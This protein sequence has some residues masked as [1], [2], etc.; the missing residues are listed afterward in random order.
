MYSLNWV[1][2]R[3]IKWD[4]YGLF[5]LN[6][7]KAMLQSGVV[8]HPYQIDTL[9]WPTWLQ[10]EGGFNPS[11]LSVQ[12][13]PSYETLPTGGQVWNYTMWEATQVEDRWFGP[14]RRNATRLLVPHE[15]LVDV[16]KPHINDVPIHVVPGGTCP[17]EF[18]IAHRSPFEVG[19]PYTF[20][21]LGDRGNRKGW[22]SVWRCFWN[23]F[24]DSKDV[25]LIIKA[26]KGGLSEMWSAGW[27]NRVVFYRDDVDTMREVY[28]LADCFVFPSRGEGWGMPPREFA[29]TGK[30][31]IATRWSGL[32]NGL[33]HWGLPLDKVTLVPSTLPGG[34]EWAMVDDDELT[35]KM[36]WCFENRVEARAKGLKAAQWLR[37]NQTWM[38]SA[39]AMIKLME[40]YG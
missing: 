2:Y 5:G 33:D 22:D 13:M 27:D 16:F 25:R 15:F 32:E 20:L 9:K 38:H 29:M 8:I 1:N 11:H 18:P 35:A 3:Y 26:R 31:V 7:V 37:D 30:P 6:M 36:L 34:G 28:Q 21:A 10:I 14:I 17:E 12:L 24:G 19:R 4:G 39:Q 23:A 40:S